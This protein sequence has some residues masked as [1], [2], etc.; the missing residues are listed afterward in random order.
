MFIPMNISVTQFKAHCL[1]LIEKVRKEKVSMVITRHGKP[2]AELVPI[3]ASPTSELFG[4]SGKSTTIPGNILTTD[5]HWD[6][7]N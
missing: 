5:E 2:T 7:E 6:A 1:G 3:Q 4:H